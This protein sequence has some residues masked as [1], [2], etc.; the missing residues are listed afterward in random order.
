MKIFPTKEDNVFE[1]GSDREWSNG[2]RM[3]LSMS[4][5]D[6]LKEWCR[7]SHIHYSTTGNTI[8]FFNK[9]DVI[10]FMLKWNH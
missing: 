3:P 10:M 6:D 5:W 9:K 4:E 2:W 8:S 1:I 7:K